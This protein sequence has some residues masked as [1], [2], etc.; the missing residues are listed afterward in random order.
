[1]TCDGCPNGVNC[2]KIGLNIEVVVLSGCS[3]FYELCPGFGAVSTKHAAVIRVFCWCR[4]VGSGDKTMVRV[5]G[6]NVVGVQVRRFGC[7][8]VRWVVRYK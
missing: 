6:G 1:M 3:I 7:V 4:S 8:C 2:L 5:T